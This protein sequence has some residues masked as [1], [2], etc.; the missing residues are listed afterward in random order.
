MGILRKF[1]K[2]FLTLSSSIFLLSS[3]SIV[4]LAA[5]TYYK[6][7]ATVPVFSD[8]E[9]T[10]KEK[11]TTGSAYNK[12]EYVQANRKLMSWIENTSGDN[13]TNKVTY[14]KPGKYTMDYKGNASQY[15]GKKVRLNISTAPSNLKK[16]ETSG[17]WTP[18]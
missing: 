6:Y 13:L 14:S 2:I 1:K 10:A 8:F 9:T 7:G 4:A 12:V 3:T 5:P 18:N 15:K 16:T 17:Q 11:K